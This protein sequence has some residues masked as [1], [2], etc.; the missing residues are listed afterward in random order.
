MGNKVQF[1][2]SN[3][4][5][6]IIT[7]DADNNVTFGEPKAFPGAVNLTL[8]VQGDSSVFYADN[9]AYYR[10]VSNQGYSGTLEMALIPEWFRVEVLGEA[11]DADGVLIENAN[12]NPK[13]FAL[14]FQVEGDEKA[15]RGAFYNVQAGR[16]SE[17]ASTKSENVEPQTASLSITASALPNTLDVRASTTSDTAP[18]IYDNWFKSVHLRNGEYA[19]SAELKALSLGALTLT[20]SFAPETTEYTATTTNATNTISAVAEQPSATIDITVNGESV[21]NGSP[22]TW[23]EDENTVEIVVT[24]GEAT[25]TYTVTVTKE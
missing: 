4:H 2:L 23:G 15:R 20:P 10:P 14:M 7:T 24:N 18:D 12:A 9:I 3:V 21:A 8:D 19:P 13:S 11:K 6:A 17:N 5:I 1:G 16:P 22:I 25:K